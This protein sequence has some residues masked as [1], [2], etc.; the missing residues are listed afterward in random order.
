MMMEFIQDCTAIIAHVHH[1]AFDKHQLTS[2]VAALN[3]P[4]SRE[5][6]ITCIQVTYIS[7]FN[8]DGDT[9]SAAT[10][11]VNTWRGEC[12]FS[13]SQPIGTA[14]SGLH[15]VVDLSDSQ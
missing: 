11:K 1:D 4:R 15:G 5:L 14:D 3:S 10:S 13:L 8:F 12:K 2:A 9:R 7:N 6:A